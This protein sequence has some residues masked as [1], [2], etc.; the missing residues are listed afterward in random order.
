LKTTSIITEIL[1]GPSKYLMSSCTDLNV[2]SGSCS[3]ST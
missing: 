3:S 2:G 1:T